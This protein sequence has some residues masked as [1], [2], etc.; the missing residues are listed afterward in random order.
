[1]PSA[2]RTLS[3][4]DLHDHVR[5]EITGSLSEGCVG[6]ELEWL[7]VFRN[8]PAE[9][10]S[11]DLLKRLLEPE[12]PLPSGGRL[13]F[14]PGGQLEISSAPASSVGVICA[15]AASADI[16][17]VQ[18][19]LDQAGIR[20][21][22]IGLDPY[23]RNPRVLEMPRYRAMEAYFDS[24]WPN[25]RRMMRDTAAIQVNLDAGLE[26]QA[27]RW[28]LVHALGPV[29]LACFSHSAL[30]N[31]RPTGW[32]ST[33]MAIWQSLDASR[34]S[35][36]AHV[37]DPVNDWSAYAMAANVMFISKANDLVPVLS[38]M[39]FAQWMDRG[40][41]LGYPTIEDL[42]L[43]LT[44]LFP[45]IRPRGWLELRM[46]DALPE[47]WWRVPVAICMALAYDRLAAKRA[48]KYLEPAAGLWVEAAMHGMSHPVLARA[49]RVCFA[50][51][52]N[53]LEGM[54]VDSET[55]AATHDYYDRYVRRGRSPADDQLNFWTAMGAVNETNIGLEEI[56]T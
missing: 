3:V 22:G 21:V 8:N 53:A 13:T 1:M 47:P 33:R 12:K 26:D 28:R 27:G 41:E 39:T 17:L 32:R 55:L 25:G 14:E 34:T 35:P 49:A 54:E 40:H 46:I 11:H 56:W 18:A 10:V 29:L 6:V 36:A 38:P 19:K 2:H 4:E 51:A 31:G 48:E 30:S 9:P 16:E 37:D 43:H 23:R 50:N 45:P 44:T 15:D 5:D 20:M 42:S 7:T 24:A 52:I